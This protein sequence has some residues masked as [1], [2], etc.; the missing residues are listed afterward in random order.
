[1][2]CAA[3][4]TSISDNESGIAAQDATARE[5]AA[6]TAD[7]TALRSARRAQGVAIGRL[8]RAALLIEQQRISTAVSAGSSPC[9]ISM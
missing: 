4:E 7:S 6:V 9:G 8:E 1:M 2:F 5:R 3:R